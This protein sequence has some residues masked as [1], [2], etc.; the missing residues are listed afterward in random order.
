MSRATSA[1]ATRRDENAAPQ[2]TGTEMGA[3]PFEMAEPDFL[4]VAL[5]ARAQLGAR[6]P[7][8]APTIVQEGN[9]E[10]Q[11]SIAA[12]QKFGGNVNR[13]PR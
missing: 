1:S 3:A 10:R 2:A 13:R 5:N 8:T 4:I 9:I 7:H 12:G 11:T 6:A